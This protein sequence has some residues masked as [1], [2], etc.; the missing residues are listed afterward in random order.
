[1]CAGEKEIGGIWCGF[2]GWAPVEKVCGGVQCLHPKRWWKISMKEKS[3][4]DIVGTANQ[5]LG[6]AVLGRRMR[7]RETVNDVVVREK[8][9]SEVFINSPPL[10]RCIHLMRV[11]NWVRM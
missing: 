8:V 10:S 2:S 5:A 9:R 3:A 4:N 7:A 1:M 11:W 6:L